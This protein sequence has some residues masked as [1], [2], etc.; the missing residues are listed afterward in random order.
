MQLQLPQV[1]GITAKSECILKLDMK[2]ELNIFCCN[3]SS[4]N[5]TIS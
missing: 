1:A 3:K 4:V 5:I 2:I